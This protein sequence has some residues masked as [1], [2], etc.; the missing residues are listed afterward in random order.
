MRLLAGLQMVSDILVLE[1]REQ[2]IEILGCTTD[3]RG[4][5]R[6]VECR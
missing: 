3:G 5:V 6:L 4:Q 2:L 1:H